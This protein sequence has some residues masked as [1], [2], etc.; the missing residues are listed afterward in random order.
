MIAKWMNLPV[1]IFAIIL[2]SLDVETVSSVCCANSRLNAVAVHTKRPQA[3]LRLHASSQQ[4]C[5]IHDMDPVSAKSALHEN[6]ECDDHR[7][8]QHLRRV[9]EM[10]LTISAK[11]PASLLQHVAKMHVDIPRVRNPWGMSGEWGWR[12]LLPDVHILEDVLT[13]SM[14]LPQL[15]ILH[16]EFCGDCGHLDAT[17]LQHAKEEVGQHMVSLMDACSERGI[18][19]NVVGM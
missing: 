5:L 18:S 16:V 9:H 15:R 6:C 12:D 13:I 4:P 1:E 2:D 11:P 19:V 7:R 10:A 8:T 14:H 3:A 17:W